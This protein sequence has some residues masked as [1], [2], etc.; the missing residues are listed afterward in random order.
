MEEPGMLDFFI[1]LGDGDNP[2]YVGQEPESDID[3]DAFLPNVSEFQELINTLDTDDLLQNLQ[4]HE[5][6]LQEA[7]KGMD[8][9]YSDEIP[10]DDHVFLA[11]RPVKSLSSPDRNGS[12]ENL[13]LPKTL[14]A[15]TNGN[16]TDQRVYRQKWKDWRRHE[17]LNSDDEEEIAV[18]HGMNGEDD[19]PPPPKDLPGKIWSTVDSGI[20]SLRDTDNTDCESLGTCTYRDSDY[21]FECSTVGTPTPKHSADYEPIDSKLLSKVEITSC[22]DCQKNSR[23][24]SKPS[25][26]VFRSSRCCDASHPG[27]EQTC[28]IHQRKSNHDRNV[29]GQRN[30]SLVAPGSL[31]RDREEL[32]EQEEQNCSDS[33]TL[34]SP[35][36]PGTEL[37]AI[38]EED[39]ITPN[40]S[41]EEED[42][43]EVEQ[44]ISESASSPNQPTS[45]VGDCVS[46]C[47]S[48]PVTCTEA[49]ETEY[50]E[51]EEED[52]EE[53]EEEEE[54]NESEE[55]EEEEEEEDGEEEEEYEDTETSEDEEGEGAEDGE[56]ESSELA[57]ES[58]ASRLG[59]S[60]EEEIEE[61]ENSQISEEVESDT[62]AYGLEQS[63]E[64]LDFNDVDDIDKSEDENDKTD[65]NFFTSTAEISQDC[66]PTMCSSNG[67][68]GYSPMRQ[69]PMPHLANQRLDGHSHDEEDV[70]RM[71]NLLPDEVKSQGTET[72]IKLETTYPSHD[73]I[74]DDNLCNGHSLESTC[75]VLPRKQK[76][77]RGVTSAVVNDVKRNTSSSLTTPNNSS[78]FVKYQSLIWQSKFQEE[79]LKHAY[80]TK[81]EGQKLLTEIKRNPVVE[82][83]V[84]YNIGFVPVGK[85]K[86][87]EGR[88]ARVSEG[89]FDRLTCEQ[90]D[91]T[92]FDQKT[93][94]VH[95]LSTTAEGSLC[96]DKSTHHEDQITPDQPKQTTKEL[97]NRRFKKRP[98]KWQDRQTV[99]PIAVEADERKRDRTEAVHDEAIE[100]F[101]ELGRTSIILRKKLSKEC[102]QE[103]RSLQH[104]DDQSS[105]EVCEKLHSSEDMG[106][107][108]EALEK[109][110]CDENPAPDGEQRADE[111]KTMEW[112]DDLG[113]TSE[114]LR[115]IPPE[116]YEDIMN[117][118]STF[119]ESGEDTCDYQEADSYTETNE[120]TAD[121][122]LVLE[123]C[124]YSDGQVKQ[125]QSDLN[126][127]I[128]RKEMKGTDLDDDN[129]QIAVM[130]EEI[131]NEFET[132]QHVTTRGNTDILNRCVCMEQ[133]ESKCSPSPQETALEAEINPQSPESVAC[134]ELLHSEHTEMSR[135]CVE[136]ADGR[137]NYHNLE[138]DVLPCK[139]MEPCD[140]LNA[141]S[142]SNKKDDPATVGHTS[143]VSHSPAKSTLLHDK[144]E[145]P[146]SRHPDVCVSEGSVSPGKRVK[147]SES[148]Q[149]IRVKRTDDPVRRTETEILFRNQLCQ[150]VKS[151]ESSEEQSTVDNDLGT[152]NGGEVQTDCAVT[153]DVSV[154]VQEERKQKEISCDN[155]LGTRN[156]S[157]VQTDCAV[158]TD[159]SV[160][161]QEEQK[162]Q[163]EISCDNDLGT[164][165]DSEAQIDCAV[166]TDVSVI[167]QEEQKQKEISCDND[168]GTRNDSEVQI[169]CAG[170]TD[171]S[172]IVQEEQKQQKEISY[173]NDLGTRNDS[174]ARQIV[175][176]VSVIVQKEQKQ[177]KEIPCDNDLGT[178]NDGE[179]L[180]DCAVTTDVSA[181]VQEEQKQQKEISCDNDLGT[182]IDSEVQTDSAVT[183]DASV[184]VQ[185]EQKQQKEIP[186]D[187][188]LG[189]RNDGEVQ[190]DCAGATDDSAI[191]QEEQKQ[192]KEISY[193]NDL[194]TRNDGEVQTDCA[195]AT[196]D[197]AIVQ[198]EQKQQKEI[199]YDNDLG[200]RNDGE[201]QTD[202]AGATDDSAIVQ[203]E[204]KQQK[205]ISYD[206]DLGTRNDGEVQ[207]DCAGATDDSAIAQEEQKQQKEISVKN[208]L[209]GTNETVITK[210]KRGRPKKQKPDIKLSQQTS[211]KVQ[212]PVD[213]KEQTDNMTKATEVS[214]S[215]EFTCTVVSGAEN[216]CKDG[217]GDLASP[218]F[219]ACA[220]TASADSAL[221]S[222][223][224]TTP[225]HPDASVM[226]PESVFFSDIDEPGRT[227]EKDMHKSPDN[228]DASLEAMNTT[229]CGNDDTDNKQNNDILH[230]D[231]HDKDSNEYPNMEADIPSLDISDETNEPDVERRMNASAKESSME[232]PCNSQTQSGSSSGKTSFE[233]AQVDGDDALCS[234]PVAT[235]QLPTNQEDSKSIHS[236]TEAVVP[237]IVSLTNSKSRK[238]GRRKGKKV[239][240]KSVSQL[241]SDSGEVNPHPASISS[242]EPR[243]EDFSQDS[244]SQ[245]VAAEA[246]LQESDHLLCSTSPVHDSIDDTAKAKVDQQAEL[247]DVGVKTKDIDDNEEED[248]KSTS[249]LYL[250]L[251]SVSV[252]PE[253]LPEDE[254]FYE[255]FDVDEDALSQAA[256]T[257]SQSEG[258]ESRL[259]TQSKSAATS[260]RRRGRKR[261][262]HKKTSSTGRS[263]LLSEDENSVQRELPRV[264][265]MESPERC[266][267]QRKLVEQSEEEDVEEKDGNNH[268]STPC[269][270]S[271]RPR[272]N[273]SYREEDMAGSLFDSDGN[274]ECD[275]IK[276][277]LKVRNN[278]KHEK[279]DGGE[280]VQN[281]PSPK[282]KMTRATRSSRRLQ[283][284]V[285]AK[286]DGP[287]KEGN[288]VSDVDSPIVQTATIRQPQVILSKQIHLENDDFLFDEWNP[289]FIRNTRKVSE[290]SDYD[291]KT[292]RTEEGDLNEHSGSQS[293]SE[294]QT[295]S[296]MEETSDV[297]AE[298]EDRSHDDAT[299]AQNQ[300]PEVSGAGVHVDEEHASKE[301]ADLPNLSVHGDVDSQSLQSAQP[302]QTLDTR[303]GSN[304]QR[305]KGRQTK[306]RK[307]PKLTREPVRKRT[308]SSQDTAEP[309][310]AEP[311]S[312]EPQVAMDALANKEPTLESGHDAETEDLPPESLASEDVPPEGSKPQG[313]GSKKKSPK[314]RKRK[315]SL[316]ALMN[317]LDK[318][319]AS[320]VKV[321]SEFESLPSSP[322]EEDKTTPPSKEV[323]KRSAAPKQRKTRRS[324][325]ARKRKQD[326]ESSMATE[327]GNTESHDGNI[328]EPTCLPSS[329]LSTSQ[330][331]L[332]QSSSQDLEPGK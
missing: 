176:D 99:H 262:Y 84:N 181:I 17:D 248:K 214:G 249:N 282:T 25:Y 232:D 189:T 52:E 51:E 153:T 201:V 32:E 197:S 50:E 77:K 224:S 21:D 274:E 247:D 29:F 70:H 122:Q 108:K 207:T 311:I 151:T 72:N 261:Q 190:T 288:D 126:E 186:C 226:S 68:Y 123:R 280:N 139:D 145:A 80:S 166:T 294:K 302:C 40:D 266:K 47:C 205:E 305:K 212:E 304:K 150:S 7:A 86:N 161:V 227:K 240:K 63:E 299:S 185:E 215:T 163:K 165:I 61:E 130:D 270:T 125:P 200:T 124:Y 203:E 48:S 275:R 235:A 2:I 98:L 285:E 90:R 114:S 192:Q 218:T 107:D 39:E 115:E 131:C 143:S 134:N 229:E 175:L 83:D 236:D 317:I 60:D 156:D 171:D 128:P 208:Y 257:D 297:T 172:A 213:Q 209:S 237:C 82:T 81:N 243:S 316:R 94:V 66:N 216:Q 152:R 291:S 271:L 100:W 255:L 37:G 65:L 300:C 221:G 110:M 20:S 42:S 36:T 119:S 276:T 8:K 264:R 179:A 78:N 251:T 89:K 129:G 157:E 234:N 177:Q 140:G 76:N 103:R 96:T 148:V 278:V 27:D 41:E 269:R 310:S 223:D 180:T 79:F 3:S 146:N 193:D 330:E 9:C 314:Q 322:L 162:Q 307:G 101:D 256:K 93:D 56:E 281:K 319:S 202:C 35:K 69:E 228:H 306:K 296:K 74:V 31:L 188:D 184:I 53:E 211:Q 321:A 160:I 273:I 272:A 54:D 133:I 331:N 219:P 326:E 155:E 329:E 292:S 14:S 132:I 142:P 225:D 252:E 246:S 135:T 290:N 120:C 24:N 268:Q 230:S 10:P 194:G 105:S 198:E 59:D 287:E 195:G 5:Q 303:A 67:Y 170:A 178:R 6:C 109:C 199:S 141:K 245:T 149:C 265:P 11:P 182:R 43:P 327:A 26:S 136:R 244:Q 28:S 167:V 284:K 206:N 263:A 15:K 242:C 75:T 293:I 254:I 267:R 301:E 33:E 312:Q 113:R 121:L 260:R 241:N 62:I 55:E 283:E 49:G 286:A 277:H 30:R 4:K 154:I 239:H 127:A 210:R 259:S 102:N 220:S 1:N 183:T 118:A 158:P 91:C 253:D 289:E 106:F 298:S 147:V 332:Q 18:G 22:Q 38:S 231:S 308:R 169:D 58:S 313:Q 233:N 318:A 309:P 111:D 324:Q 44:A 85:S 95:Q 320:A 168:L 196:D 315:R 13:F 137:E 116:C 12:P 250:G 164:R 71:N 328:E 144:E 34:N 45:E 222:H 187:N 23:G 97:H 279:N 117:E 204:Q 173:D 46:E 104:Q 159:V 325:Q 174:E 138:C 16:L 191:V 87:C 92:H 19:S 64:D 295:D 112:F 73:A 238:R 88:R 57:E 258:E 323:Q 217:D